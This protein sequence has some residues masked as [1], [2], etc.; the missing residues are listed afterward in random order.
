MLTTGLF[1]RE[2]I[3]ICRNLDEDGASF[4]NTDPITNGNAVT[5]EQNDELVQQQ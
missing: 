5:S 4:L 1:L 2:G 3:G